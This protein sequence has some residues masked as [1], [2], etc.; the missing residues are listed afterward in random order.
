MIRQ[1]PNLNNAVNSASQLMGK[2]PFG[3]TSK[4]RRIQHRLVY[5]DLDLFRSVIVIL[6]SFIVTKINNTAKLTW[7]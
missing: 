5:T 2:F 3:H 7:Y 1:I 6:K 4:D